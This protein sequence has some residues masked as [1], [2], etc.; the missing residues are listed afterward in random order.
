MSTRC[1]WEGCY[2]DAMGR[3]WDLAGG[4]LG[5]TGTRRRITAFQRA[6]LLSLLTGARPLNAHYG[7]CRTGAD[8]ELFTMCRALR[9]WVI[10]HPS[11]MDH[12]RG[13]APA[14]E[15][16]EPKPPLERNRDIVAESDYLVALPFQEA[17][18]LRSGTW[19]TVRHARGEGKTVVLLYPSGRVDIQ[20]P[21]W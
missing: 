1:P 14:G 11:D 6:L 8:C 13:F 5:F 12:M 4:S 3:N 17:E 19:A 21:A 7:D 15:I 16:R 18:I 10:S 2:G 9:I 20:R